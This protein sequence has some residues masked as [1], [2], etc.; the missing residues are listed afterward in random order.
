M[1]RARLTVAVTAA[2]ALLLAACGGGDEDGSSAPEEKAAVKDLASQ[3]ALAAVWP[4]TGLPVKD[5]GS[6]IEE[7]PVYVVKIDNTPSS[8]PQVGLKTADLVVEELVE[9]GSTRLAVFYYSKLPKEVGPVR[10]MRASDIGIVK[11]VAGELVTSGAAT[12]T[13]GRLR[14]SKVTWHEE[15]AK[16]VY[17]NRGRRAPYNVFADLTSLASGA[18]GSG[19]R[20]DDYLEWGDSTDLPTGKPAKSI[21]A[22][23]SGGH[24]SRWTYASGRYGL[25][26]TFAAQGDEFKADNVLVIRATVGDAGYRDPAGNPVPETK[27]EGSGQ[28]VLFHKGKAIQVTWHKSGLDGQLRLKTSQGGALK[29][30]AGRTWIELVPTDQNAG[31]TFR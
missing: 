26:G 30:P 11:P 20:P 29:V 14:D 27:F 7:H 23:F 15:G 25:D 18:K 13:Y 2:A 21:E 17:R 12:R 9:G 1:R 16:G 10:S 4:L 8:S 24:T 19:E 31:V 28:G 3:A 6:A 22:R 5:G